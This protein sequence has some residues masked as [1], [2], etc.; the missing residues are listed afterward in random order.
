M[1]ARTFIFASSVLLSLSSLAIH[2]SAS[3]FD[4]FLKP[5]VT[6]HCTKCH[7]GDEVNGKVNFKEIS[8]TEQ[9][10][11]KPKLIKEMIEVIDANDMPPEDE[12]QLDDK[13]RARLLVTLTTMLRQATT[14]DEAQQPRIRRLNRFQYNHSVKDLFRLKLDVFPLPEKLM[15]RHE[16]YLHAESNKMP[17]RVNVSSL[18]LRP[19]VGLREV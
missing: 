4:T 9:F 5:L 18:A 15:T 6:A 13:S 2:G 1:L 19:K 17:D 8:T 3:E 11:A 7:G 16:N 12:L 14:N 10:L